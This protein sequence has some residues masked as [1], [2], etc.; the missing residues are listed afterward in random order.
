[1]LTLEP[2]R[3]QNQLTITRRRSPEMEG[4]LPETLKLAMLV[5]QRRSSPV[6]GEL[7]W[8]VDLTGNRAAKVD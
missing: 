3:L 1:M 2:E 8:G 4:S 7:V 6:S 5:S